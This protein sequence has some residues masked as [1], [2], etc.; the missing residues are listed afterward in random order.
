MS[1]SA[2]LSE[3]AGTGPA[4]RNRVETLLEKVAGTE[5]HPVLAAALRN[6]S[7]SSAQLTK[8]LRKEYGQDVVKDGS[9]AEWRRR[10]SVELN[11]L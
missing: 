4:H 1:L 3:F 6:R 8:A 7:I 9:I 11:G 10:N 2:T 5:D